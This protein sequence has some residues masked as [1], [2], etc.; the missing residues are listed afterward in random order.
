M[1]EPIISVQVSRDLFRCIV[2]T[3]GEGSHSLWASRGEIYYIGPEGK[4]KVGLDDEIVKQ[5]FNDDCR[6]KLQAFMSGV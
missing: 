3:P 2:I 4:R 5:K 6:A 1:N